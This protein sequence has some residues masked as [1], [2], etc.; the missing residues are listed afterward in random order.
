[1]QFNEKLF[2]ILFKKVS[3]IKSIV[4]IPRLR[5]IHHQSWQCRYPCLSGGVCWLGRVSGLCVAGNYRVIHQPVVTHPSMLRTLARHQ[6]RTRG[7]YTSG[8]LGCPR[9]SSILTRK[10]NMNQQSSMFQAHWI[11]RYTRQRTLLHY[12][13]VMAEVKQATHC[14]AIIQHDFILPWTF[15]VFNVNFFLLCT[16]KYGKVSCFLSIFSVSVVK[17]SI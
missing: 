17:A 3:M 7:E 8:Q 13:Q 5:Q 2:W 4:K 10:Y 15:A 11:Y 6:T 16:N 9:L 12:T 1:M 14:I